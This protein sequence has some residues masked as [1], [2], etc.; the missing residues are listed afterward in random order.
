MR[1]IRNGATTPAVLMPPAPVERDWRQFTKW[2]S[3]ICLS[4][5]LLALLALFLMRRGKHHALIFPHTD[6]RH[7]FSAPHSGGNDAVV[8]FAK[9]G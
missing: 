1:Q 7:R 4:V 9:K 3:S 5:S 2:I 6:F 8:S